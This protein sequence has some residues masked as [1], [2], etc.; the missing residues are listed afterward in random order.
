MRV[1]YMSKKSIE[2]YNIYCIHCKSKYKLDSLSTPHMETDKKHWTE[3]EMVCPNCNEQ[4]FYIK[5]QITK[6]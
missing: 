5:I 3:T 2:G 1:N 6:S 4:E